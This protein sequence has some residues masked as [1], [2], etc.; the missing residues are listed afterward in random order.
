[1]PRK[2]YLPD[3]SHIIVPDNATD[4]Q[5]TAWAKQNFPDAF[6]AV[7]PEAAAP[8]ERTWGEAVTDVGAG[9]VKGL[10]S[11][12]QLPSQLTGLVSGD[13]T[14]GALGRAGKAVEEY[15]QSMKSKS[16][17]Q[18]EQEQQRRQQEAYASSGVL[19]EAG[20]AIKGTITNP[21]LLTSFLAEQIPNLIGSMGTG[22]LAKIGTK[23]ALAIAGKTAE[24]IAPLAAK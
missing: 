15:G 23:T 2:F 5:A 10:G 9:A 24:E 16:L 18:Q 3:L 6:P 21:A 22:L 8:V 17:L 7:A 13:M 12:I 11:L 1:M 14:P 19:G 4:E 20:E